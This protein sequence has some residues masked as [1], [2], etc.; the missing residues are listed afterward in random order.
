VRRAQLIH[1]HTAVA[2]CLF[3]DADLLDRALAQ[4]TGVRL[5]VGIAQTAE[6]LQQ[7]RCRLDQRI[8]A[9][10]DLFPAVGGDGR[11]RRI[12]E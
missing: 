1:R 9:E 6:Q 2:R 4:V 5:A 7:R 8:E 12:A 3:E 10:A 11:R